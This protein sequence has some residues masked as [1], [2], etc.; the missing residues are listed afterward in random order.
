MR[1]IIRSMIKAEAKR[2]KAKPSRWLKVSF[3]SRQRKIYGSDTR[4]VNQAKGTHKKRLWP[5]R[6]ALAAA[7]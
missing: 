2:E 3:D 5:S 7:K 4:K 6:I 1:K